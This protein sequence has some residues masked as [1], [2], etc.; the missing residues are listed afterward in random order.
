MVSAVAGVCFS[1]ELTS[2]FRDALTLSAFQV[3]SG[4]IELGRVD[5]KNQCREDEEA[6]EELGHHI[7]F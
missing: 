6:G 4:S 5:R 1:I 3:I 7:D 2:T